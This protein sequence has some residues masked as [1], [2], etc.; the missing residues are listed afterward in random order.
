MSTSL[1][2]IRTNENLV[3]FKCQHLLSKKSVISGR[4]VILKDFEHLQIP[5]ILRRNSLDQFMAI[6]EQVYP[7]LVH[8]F[9]ANIIFEGSRVKSRVLGKDIDIPLSQF[10]DILHSPLE[11]LMF[12]P[13]ISKILNIRTVSLRSPHLL[14]FTGVTIPAWSRTRKW[15]NSRSLPKF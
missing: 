1:D 5:Q 3:F 7:S 10:A 12:T 6:R 13:L 8:F 9:Y 4:C 14:W 2:I 11:E 15:T